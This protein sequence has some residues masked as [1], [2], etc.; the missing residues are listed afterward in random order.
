MVDW[1]LSDGTVTVYLSPGASEK[2][3][4]DKTDGLIIIPVGRQATP[5][6][7]SVK[8]T[9]E[10]IVVNTTFESRAAGNDWDALRTMVKDEGNA[11]NGEFTFVK[12][13]DTFNV[14]V[15]RIIKSEESGEGT[16]HYIEVEMEVVQ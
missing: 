13:S 6:A 15:R 1:T 14:A 3:T 12:G 11:D 7:K 8:R 10:L 9:R 16:I 4:L 2:T 5:K